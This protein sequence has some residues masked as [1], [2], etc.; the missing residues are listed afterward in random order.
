MHRQQQARQTPIRATR[1]RFDQTG[2]R[3]VN[4][5]R[6]ETLTILRDEIHSEGFNFG[7]HCHQ[8]K[9]RLN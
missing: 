8:I 3:S 6:L 4:R 1:D 5:A 9:L 2:R 7:V